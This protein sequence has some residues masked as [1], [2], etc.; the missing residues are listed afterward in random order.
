LLGDILLSSSKVLSNNAFATY[1]TC[2]LLLYKFKILI[3]LFLY[4][5]NIT[6]AI[7]KIYNI[8]IKLKVIVISKAFAFLGY[9]LGL[10]KL[11][12]LLLSKIFVSYKKH[13]IGLQT[14]NIKRFF[15]YKE[16]KDYKSTILLKAL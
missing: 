16:G 9:K 10:F 13:I 3:L 11:Y 14:D 1:N 12:L 15:C 6:I 2:N 8:T 7:F 5:G 4:K